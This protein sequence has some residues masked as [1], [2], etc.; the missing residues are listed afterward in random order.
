MLEQHRRHT[1]YNGSYFCS[2]VKGKNRLKKWDLISSDLLWPIF[3]WL[4]PLSLLSFPLCLSSSSLSVCLS[5]FL[6]LFICLSDWLI[7]Y[8]SPS[9]QT[10]SHRA[11]N[12]SSQF[13]LCGSECAFP[14]F[15]WIHFYLPPSTTM[16]IHWCSA[17]LQVQRG[18]P[19]INQEVAQVRQIVICFW[20]RMLHGVTLSIALMNTW[21]QALSSVS[22]S[23]CVMFFW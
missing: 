3:L 13:V 18:N 19:Y 2:M 17:C 1:V 5:V 4:M 11:S 23:L 21:A 8:V 10:R 16:V 14:Y 15:L 22:R 9:L 7:G 6:Y 20:A 12:F